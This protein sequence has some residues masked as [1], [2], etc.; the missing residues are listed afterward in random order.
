MIRSKIFRWSLFF[1]GTAFLPFCGFAQRLVDQVVIVYDN[2]TGDPLVGASLLLNGTR[3]DVTDSEGKVLLSSVR[4]LDSVTVSYVGYATVRTT[5]L[6]IRRND[7]RLAMDSRLNLLA[8]IVVWGRRDDSS[9][10]MP[11]LVSRL[12]ATEIS[13]YNA[14]T[15]ADA[16]ELGNQA[17]VQRSQMGGGSIVLRG[18]EANKILLVVDGVRMNN[19]IYR[20]GHLQNAITIDPAMLEQI[21][22]IHGPGS[23]LY[24]SDALGGVIHFRTKDPRFLPERS[25]GIDRLV[26]TR[27][28]SRI[29]SASNERTLHAD[30][31]Y[32]AKSWAF[33][34]S[35][36]VSDFDDLKSGSNTP[37]A[38][39]EFG[40]RPTYAVRS[41]GIDQI[42]E[43]PDPW[44]QVGS[45]YNQLDFM[46]K[47][48]YRPDDD[49]DLLLNIQYSASS[50]IPRYDQLIEPARD[51]PSGLRFSEWN[52]GPQKRLLTSMKW[53]SLQRNQYFDKATFIAAW[54][55]I[56]EDRLIR[57]FGDPWRLFNLET[58][59]VLSL[60]GDFDLNLT[61][62][63]EEKAHKHLLA[64]GFEINHNRVRSEA[65]EVN[66][67]TGKYIYGLEPT[68]YPSGNSTMGS[69]G[70]YANYNYRS[71]GE[72]LSA[73]AGIRFSLA[74]LNARFSPDDPIQ[75]PTTYLGGVSS[76]NSALT[77]ALGARY[78]P[79]KEFEVRGLASTAFRS[80]NIDDFGKV[81]PNRNFIQVPNISLDAEHAINGELTLAYTM[82]GEEKKRRRRRRRGQKQAFGMT[83]SVTGFYTYLTDAI[84]RA[85]ADLFGD[86]ILIYNSDPYRI[87]TLVNANEA[88]LY[89]F[90][91][92]LSLSLGDR[93]T[94]TT[95]ASYTYGREII[96]GQTSPLA[97]I[98]PLYGTSILKFTKDRL[99]VRA[100]MRFN[101]AKSLSEYDIGSSDNEDLATSEGA[102]AWTTYSLYSSYEVN[103]KVRVQLAVENLTDLHYRPFSSGI[104]APGRNII[105]SVLWTASNE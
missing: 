41:G 82:A 61:S 79:V 43:N 14:R 24:G 21:E 25:Q 27:I 76:T 78:R 101:G 20:N 99:E 71:P 102:L 70:I 18:F 73:N 3:V 90:S 6:K 105:L 5:V 39:P 45:A 26:E 52:Y 4:F 37:K 8:N 38:W 35:L 42:V 47:V 94:W 31:N 80:P 58:V 12:D 59:D 56:G 30:V 1:V 55:Q 91:T 60:T 22:V 63:I 17:Y 53:R 96:E 86:T 88:W 50:D 64:Y 54:Q 93:W 2:Q 23:L 97:H 9:D 95:G 65:G 36:S 28:M 74:H 40:R 75:W 89:G 103:A 67:E 83:A 57:R 34:T 29:S 98:P 66:I 11:Q 77:W 92:H 48:R 16:L 15:T 100:A 84:V 69:G 85:N 33:F 81:R 46:Q 62:G 7:G 72:R 104:S 49:N 44:R 32:G 68:R 87:Q 19:A 13:A 10:E 51:N